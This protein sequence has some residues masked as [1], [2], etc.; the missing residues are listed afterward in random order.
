METWLYW[1]SNS[2][3]NKNGN[4]E[5][6]DIPVKTVHLKCIWREKYFLLIWKAF[7]NTEEWLSVCDAG[8]PC[9]LPAGIT[10]N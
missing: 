10:E 1:L 3:V 6:W 4:G 5:V 9:N 8:Q 7:R 2:K